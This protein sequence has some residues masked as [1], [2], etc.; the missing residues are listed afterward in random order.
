MKKNKKLAVTRKKEDEARPWRVPDKPVGP[1]VTLRSSRI[2][3]SLQVRRVGRFT[4][5][6]GQ[7]AET[8][9]KLTGQSVRFTVLTRRAREHFVNVLCIDDR[10]RA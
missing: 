2:K 4:L 3:Q 1:G 7:V 6:T 10:A 9:A 5:V 8:K